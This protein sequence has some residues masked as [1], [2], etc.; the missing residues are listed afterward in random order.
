[1]TAP[2]FSI[3]TVVRN[4]EGELRATSSSLSAQDFRDFEWVIIDG[5]S[6]DGTRRFAE[7]QFER[8]A[9]TGVSEPDRGIYDAMNKGLERAKGEYV[10][11]LNAGDCLLD[12]NSLGTVSEALHH[13]GLP[14]VGFFGSIMDFGT[15]RIVRRTK[16]PAYIWHGQPS[17]HQATFVRKE[18]HKKVPFSLKY[19]IVGDY[20]ALARM[21]MRGATMRSFPQIIGINTFE[22]SSVSGR[23]KM[24]LIK[25]AATI[26]REVLGLSTWW[27]L[28]SV[29]RRAINSL[30]VKVFTAT[31]S[32]GGY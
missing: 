19:K 23:Q 27:I 12:A 16:S 14:D 13:S 18:L 32:R 7:E 2:F 21:R 5:A 9:A 8:G 6:S 30:V 15:R 28:V 29:A 26:Q 24:L 10:L 4:A 25:D 20:E 17:L 31:R 22:A 11:F 1:M 3:V